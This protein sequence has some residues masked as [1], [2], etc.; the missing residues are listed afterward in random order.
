MILRKQN[1]GATHSGCSMPMSSGLRMGM[2]FQCQGAT[3]VRRSP[4]AKRFRLG[5]RASS[6]LRRTS[7]QKK[8]LQQSQDGVVFSP[9]VTGWAPR[10]PP[11][12]D[13]LPSNVTPGSP[14]FAFRRTQRN[15]LIRR[16]EASQEWLAEMEVASGAAGQPVKASGSRRNGTDGGN[17][18]SGI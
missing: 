2:F 18:K 14:S 17:G 4:C 11:S 15:R 10:L 9:Q 13:R 5:L 1:H 6:L 7:P 12:M 16:C 3:R 8:W